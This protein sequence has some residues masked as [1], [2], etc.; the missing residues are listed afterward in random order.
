MRLA[1]FN[2]NSVK[3]RL[4]GLLEWLAEAAP[5]VVLLQEI[6]CQDEN[7]PAEEL[8]AAGYQ[9]AVHGQKAYNGVAILSR[10]PMTEVQTGLPDSSSRTAEDEQARF[11]AATICG[12]RVHSLYVPNGNPT[13]GPKYPYKLSWLDRLIDYVEKTL[14]P[15]EVPFVL[16]G[17][18][19]IC[20][21]D[22]DCYD[23][24]SMREDALCL[25]DVRQRYRRL[26][27][28]GLWDAWRTIYP[29]PQ[30]GYSYWDY[31]QGRF[32]KDH[33]LRIDHF[34]LSPQVADCLRTAGI[35]QRPRGR[36]RPSDHTPVWCELAW[37]KRA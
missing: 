30:V 37:E 14:L 19:N 34:L 32:Q 11:I 6:K 27:N 17:D 26:L 3:V 5:D 18:F 20:P 7:F 25:P 12:I 9:S 29:L 23:P 4:P 2:V 13:D 8:A 31:V 16:G 33:G 36:E 15:H 24:L 21:G 22:A 28:L 35:D 1:T 10:H